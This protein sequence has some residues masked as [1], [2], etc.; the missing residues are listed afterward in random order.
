MEDCSTDEQLQQETLCCQQ[1]TDEYVEHPVIDEA[2]HNRHLDLVSAG[3]H[4]I[5]ND[6]FWVLINLLTFLN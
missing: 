3:R 1:C 5:S 6:K 2:E 4:S